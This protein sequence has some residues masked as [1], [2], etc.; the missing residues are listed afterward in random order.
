VA[1]EFGSV[2]QRFAKVAGDGHWEKSLP[3]R[4]EL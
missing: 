1:L 4:N 3:R 2:I